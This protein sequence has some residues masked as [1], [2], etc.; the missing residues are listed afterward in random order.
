MLLS[1]PEWAKL[2]KGNPFPE[3]VDKP[4]SLHAFAL[5][6]RRNRKRGHADAELR[7]MRASWSKA[8]S[9]TSTRRK[10]R[11][12]EAAASHRPHPRRRLDGAQLE[13]GA[14]ADGTGEKG[15]VAHWDLGSQSASC[16]ARAAR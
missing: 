2:V 12:V 10:V 4:T 6:S 11:H 15:I 16:G 13:H 14:E 5:R 9:S 3:A 8:R 1:R 7:P